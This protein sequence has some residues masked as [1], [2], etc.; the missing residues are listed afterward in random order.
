ME[1]VDNNE[2]QKNASP[3][4]SVLRMF[5][6][7]RSRLVET[8][9]RNRLVHVNRANSRGNVLNIVNERSERVHTLRENMQEISGD[10]YRDIM[11]QFKG[12]ST[13]SVHL[14]KLKVLGKSKA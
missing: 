3:P 12:S 11:G 4:P 14:N 7:V 2:A 13:V 9:T 10:F 1:S 6:E 8:G 5:D